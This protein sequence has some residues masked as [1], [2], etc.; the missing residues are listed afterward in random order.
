MSKRDD[1]KLVEDDT[2]RL[3]QYWKARTDIMK[4]DRNFRD[5]DVTTSILVDNQIS[6]RIHRVISNHPQ[7]YWDWAVASLANLPFKWEIPKQSLG[8]EVDADN[9]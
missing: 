8:D 7:A 3:T 4:K 2:T 5:L 9:H 6:P 1:L